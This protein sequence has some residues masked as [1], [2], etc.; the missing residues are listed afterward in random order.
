MVCRAIVVMLAVL[1]AGSACGQ[2]AIRIVAGTS[3]LREVAQELLGTGVTLHTLLPPASCPGH[4]DMRPGDIEAVAACDLLLLHPWQEAMPN[5]TG[6]REAAGIAPERVRVVPVPGNWMH[7]ETRAKAAQALALLLGREYPERAADIDA[8]AKRV[9][10]TCASAG[11]AA[12]ERIAQLNPAGMGILCAEQQAD[13]LRYAGLDVLDTYGRPEGMSV[14]RTSE[15]TRLAKQN[16]VALVV[17]NLQ[18]GDTKMGARL[19]QECGAVH[20]VLSNF[21]GAEPGADTWEQMLRVNIERL[22][23]GIAQWRARR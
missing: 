19:A 22:A 10:E 17:D 13:L 18:S 16:G 23:A 9:A 2:P 4:Y 8:G 20:V 14:A 7:P 11:A 6:A 1:S 15:L 3:L 21:P 12:R 5:V